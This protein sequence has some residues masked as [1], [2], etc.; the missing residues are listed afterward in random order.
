MWPAGGGNRNR[1]L[2]GRLRADH[3]GS[4]SLASDRNLGADDLPD[5]GYE[6][7]QKLLRPIVGADLF[8]YFEHGSTLFA[9]KAPAAWPRLIA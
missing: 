3:P 7:L 4:A 5:Q 8:P 2:G 9:A 1:R 6:V